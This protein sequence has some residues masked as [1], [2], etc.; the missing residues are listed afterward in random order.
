MNVLPIITLSEQV[1]EK[2]LVTCSLYNF[3]LNLIILYNLD[4]VIL[5]FG[6]KREQLF[7]YH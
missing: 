7:Y 4:K 3:L 2:D 1:L 6:L 5:I